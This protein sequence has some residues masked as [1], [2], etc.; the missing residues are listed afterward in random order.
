MSS[1]PE[2]EQLVLSVA[3]TDDGGG[4]ETVARKRKNKSGNSFWDRRDENVSGIGYANSWAT[5]ATGSTVSTGQV[6]ALAPLPLEGGWIWHSGPVSA[7]HKVPT[8]DALIDLDASDEDLASDDYDSD[9]SQ[10]SHG[11]RKQNKWFHKFFDNL[12]SLSF[13]QI[14]E[15]E[16]QWDCPACQGGT[17]A[18][19][20][21]NLQGLLDHAKTRGRVPGGFYM[22]SLDMDLK[23]SIKQIHEKINA[24]EENLAMLLQQERAKVQQENTNLSTNDD[25]RKRYTHLHK[26]ALY[27]SDTRVTKFFWFLFFLQR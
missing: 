20:R 17:G 3:E 2:I 13:E 14:N 23:E 6:Q 10:K 1:S 16:R 8:T 21:H 9:V 22:D 25:F 27:F 24:K 7:Q 12:D 11:T 26:P 15:P 4:W 19:K 18:V 5:Q